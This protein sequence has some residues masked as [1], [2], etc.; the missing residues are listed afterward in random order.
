MST[1]E[2]IATVLIFLLVIVLVFFSFREFREP[3]HDGARERSGFDESIGQTFALGPFA[4]LVSTS[5]AGG[6]EENCE[7]LE[8]VII[9]TLHDI[10]ERLEAQKLASFGGKEGV[11]SVNQDALALFCNKNAQATLADSQGDMLILKKLPFERAV[12]PGGE[13]ADIGT[14]VHIDATLVRSGEAAPAKPTTF[15]EVLIPDRYLDE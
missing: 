13:S 4:T 15:G 10:K 2:K 14:R 7:R 5:S 1:Y 12:P 9:G 11:L 6:V 3:E 8:P